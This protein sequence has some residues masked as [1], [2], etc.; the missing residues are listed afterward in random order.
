MVFTM[1]RALALRKTTLDRFRTE[2]FG[3]KL[4]EI[5]QG[6][7]QAVNGVPLDKVITD[8]RSNYQQLTQYIS[9]YEKLKSA[10]LTSNAGVGP[11]TE[12]KKVEVAG[13]QYTMAELIAAS[14]EI[15]GNKKHKEALKALLLQVM[16]NA[17][18]TAL[19]KVETQHEKVENE[20]REYLTR[21]VSGDNKA[22]TTEEIQARTQMF[23]EDKDFILVDPLNLKKKIEELEAEIKK[24]TVECDA[25]MSEQNALTTIEVDLT[26]LD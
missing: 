23:H 2:V 3:A 21:A 14:D 15:Y 4:I 11:D 20:I 1:H 17:Y 5:R 19:R 24:F 22:L 7:R 6:K 10:I 9:N 26:D 16:K 8:I 13:K 25:T 12:V 18:S